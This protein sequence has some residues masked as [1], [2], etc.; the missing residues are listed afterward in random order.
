MKRLDDEP[1]K[2]GKRTS[3]SDNLTNGDSV[4]QRNP[5]ALLQRLRLCQEAWNPGSPWDRDGAHA[6]LWG[7]LPGSFLVVTDSS[8]QNKLLCV[9]VDDQNKKVQDFPIIQT[10]SAQRLDTSHL[11]FSDLLQLVIFYSLSRDVLPLCLLIPSWVCGLTEQ[12]EHLVSHLGPKAWVCPSADLLPGTMSPG[13]PEAP[14]NVMCT[15]QLTAD[16]GA[17]CFINPLYLQEH[18]DD[19]LTHSPVSTN[20]INRP[21]TSKRD[22]RLSTARPWAGAGLKKRT[23]SVEES[24]VVTDSSG[25]LVQS[26]VSPVTTTGVILRR[27][28]NPDTSDLQKRVSVDSI[29]SPI[30]QSP[31]RVSWV[32]DKLWN[33]PAP[34][35]LLHPPCLEFDSLSMSSIEEEPDPE[36]AASPCQVQNSPRLPLADKVKNRLSAVG[37]VF[38]GFI[39][40]QKRLSKRVQEMSERKGSPFAEALKGFLEQTLKMRAAC[41]VTSTEILQEVRSSLTALRETLYDSVEIQSIID[42]LG[43]VPDF[44]LDTMMEQ[45]LHKVALKPLFSH[46]N[47]CM[48]TA[49]QQDGSLHRLQAN[50][51]T[52]MSRSLEELEG[53]A[54]AGVPDAAMLE[55]IQQRWASMHQQYSPQKKVEMLLK[56]CKNIY[57][58]MTVNA[59]PGVV[60]GADDFLPCLTWVLLRSDVVTLQIDTDY[61]MEL[62]DPSQLQGEGGYYLTSLYAS[63]YYISSFRSRLAARQ[64]SAEAQKSLSQWH[65]R[66]TLHCNQSRRS[67]NRRTFRRHRSN[68]KSDEES[69]EV[70]ASDAS[71]DNDQTHTADVTETLQSVTENFGEEKEEEQ[72][73]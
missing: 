18:G 44:E 16:N 17:L 57:H 23:E 65:R 49:R 33:P 32:E 55:K 21:F 31:H 34:S 11:A 7:R 20:L 38:G 43:D 63:L 27:A 40:P 64:L 70:N 52:L 71:K 56:V 36:Q 69:E 72:N 14:D 3:F 26:P 42:T 59:K 28:S 54:G 10:G 60:F 50:Q 48:K 30:P 15:I 29:S 53:T 66:R 46:L 9:S 19:W 22:R 51:K 25:S 67:R 45:A 2:S 58:S 4:T 61:M 37:Q 13:T 1:T 12:P 39:N 35:S 8:S 62:L 5:V 73:G 6:A 68:E 24:P 41:G 47:E